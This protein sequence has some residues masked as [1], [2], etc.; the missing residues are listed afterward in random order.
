MMFMCWVLWTR[1][2]SDYSTVS[3]NYYFLL[4]KYCL[5][6]YLLLRKSL[7]VLICHFSQFYHQTALTS[8][9]SHRNMSRSQF[10]TITFKGAL[11]KLTVFILN[12][13]WLSVYRLKLQLQCSLSKTFNV[14]QKRNKSRNTHT[15]FF[16]SERVTAH[17]PH[18]ALHRW[19]PA[20]FCCTKYFTSC[21]R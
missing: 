18:A 14:V 10:S 7:M 16:V 1:L 17:F 20:G 6:L 3:L 11:L 12:P 2:S 19:H 21:L 5:L 13:L 4:Q 15:T 9:I 8:L